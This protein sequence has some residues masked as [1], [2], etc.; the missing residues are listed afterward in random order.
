MKQGEL[1]A[2]TILEKFG[3]EFDNTYS[4]TNC[5]ESM[6]DLKYK[7]GGCLEVT[8]TRHNHEIYRKVGAYFKKPIEEQLKIGQEVSEAI[9]RVHNEEYK[10][11]DLRLSV[12][13]L[14]QYKKDCKLLKE[15]MGYDPTSFDEPYSEFKCDIPAIHFS[16]DNVIREI[17]K[18][19]GKKY[20]NGDVD[21]FVFVTE[22]EYEYFF[23]IFQE[24]QWNGYANNCFRT[25]LTSPFQVIYICVW[26]LVHQ[27]YN[28]DFP[29]IRKLEKTQDDGIQ[30]TT[31][32]R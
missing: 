26:D 7:G 9:H 29:S 4:D 28:I 13:G 8:H 6:S 20:P 2:R 19:K 11:D 14:K 30:V 24:I 25:I 23:K 1:E 17:S 15:H 21:L 18:D 10:K 12:E 22:E 5:G 27:K 31:M 32:Q 16:A 3:I